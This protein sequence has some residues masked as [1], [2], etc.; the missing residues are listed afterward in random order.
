MIV[1]SKQTN[2]RSRSRY[3]LI[4]PFSATSITHHFHYTDNLNNSS[5]EIVNACFNPKY[6]AKECVC[7]ATVSSISR[8]IVPTW[9]F[10]FPYSTRITKRNKNQND[11]D[12]VQIWFHRFHRQSTST[13]IQFFSFLLPFNEVAFCHSA[14]YTSKITS[15][16]SHATAN[17]H[18][19]YD[20]IYI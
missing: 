10:P 3:E 6:F 15:L 7:F 19:F 17:I 14:A 5:S 8:S 1:V 12:D 2:H 11:S 13:A 20:H 4:H 9:Y 18:T 16:F